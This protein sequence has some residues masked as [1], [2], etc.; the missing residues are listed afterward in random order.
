MPIFV[1]SP[2]I[3][4]LINMAAGYN[5]RPSQILG[6]T[7]DYAAYCFD[8]ACYFITTEIQNGK[9]PKFFKKAKSFTDIYKDYI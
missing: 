1:K 9:E 5:Q 4:Y 2:N 8:Q 7:D 6:I 3:L